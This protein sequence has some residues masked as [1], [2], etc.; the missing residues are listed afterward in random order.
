[1]DFGSSLGGKG[2]I[3]SV[4]DKN[5]LSG[6]EDSIGPVT[7]MLG[8]V[9]SKGSEGQYCIETDWP[10]LH[11]IK[12]AEEDLLAQIGAGSKEAG[13]LD[14][15][16]FI[17]GFCRSPDAKAVTAA[18]CCFGT[19]LL[20]PDVPVKGL[21]LSTLVAKC[22][23]DPV[24]CGNGLLVK[25]HSMKSFMSLRPTAGTTAQ[26]LAQKIQARLA[27]PSGNAAMR[28]VLARFFKVNDE[29]VIITGVSV[30]GA[31]ATRSRSR[32][33]QG[34]SGAGA[35]GSGGAVGESVELQFQIMSTDEAA[36]EGA[37]AATQGAGA[38]D[39]LATAMKTDSTLAL[40]TQLGSVGMDPAP[41]QIS[42]GRDAGASGGGG[43]GVGAIVGI[44]VGCVAVVGII[45]ALVVVSSSRSRNKETANGTNSASNTNAALQ[46]GTVESGDPESASESKYTAQKS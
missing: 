43:L 12:K 38:G 8:S 9:C 35:S 26:E 15:E 39:A 13:S 24:P 14:D 4:E 23:A 1:M 6:L 18:G 42:V 2:G 29:E 33:L 37:V 30:E 10:V 20:N 21:L 32:R 41:K 25:R 40:S 44:A 31:A 46:M 17:A 28:G 3:G 36:L 7:D 16:A 27:L 22:G 45:A 34:G 5:P 11:M 19:A